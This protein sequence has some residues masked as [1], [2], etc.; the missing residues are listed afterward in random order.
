MV[1]F[2]FKGLMNA[3]S[4]ETMKQ[5]VINQVQSDAVSVSLLFEEH[6]LRVNRPGSWFQRTCSA[7]QRVDP[8]I[9][10]TDVTAADRPC[11]PLQ[12]NQAI[13]DLVESPSGPAFNSKASLVTSAADKPCQPLQEKQAVI[14]P[15]ESPSGTAFN[16][17]ASLCP[18]AQQSQVQV[19]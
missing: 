13:I 2:H 4:S 12:D 9:E 14:D 1:C 15:L 16:S 11:Q 8:G 19:M 10:T 18:S 7:L 17:K 6:V 3:P 5:V